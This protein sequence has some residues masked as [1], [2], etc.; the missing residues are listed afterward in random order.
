MANEPFQ[1][2]AADECSVEG[3]PRTVRARGWCGF[4]YQRWRLEGDVGADRPCRTKSVPVRQCTIDGCD[5]NYHARGWCYRHYERWKSYGD[6]LAPLRRNRDG[7][8]YRGL[9]HDG[10]V[11]L[12]LRGKTILEHRTVMEEILGRALLPDETVHHK[13]GVR[14][15][16]RPENLELWVSTRSGQRVS[17]L[18]AFVVE[19]YRADVEA[20]LNT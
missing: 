13:N 16:N 11:V 1:A 4:H 15:D 18:V 17:D 3:C 7:E 12:K 20:A 6:P 10:Y 14:D 2:Q 5:G 8:G 9:N 19:H